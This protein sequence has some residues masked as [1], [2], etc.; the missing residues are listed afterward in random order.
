MPWEPPVVE[1]KLHWHF[2]NATDL[3]IEVAR[4]AYTIETRWWIPDWDQ[5]H[6][7]RDPAKMLESGATGVWEERPGN[8][9]LFYF[10]DGVRIPPGETIPVEVPINIGHLMPDGAH[11][12]SIAR[13]VDARIQW[14]LFLDNA[15]RRWETRPG[16]SGRARRIRAMSRRRSGYPLGWQHPVPIKLR[17][18]R[19]SAD[20]RVQRWWP[21]SLSD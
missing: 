10:V 14:V 18:V 13:G 17:A 3:P 15:G 19:A 12:L 11:Q 5:W 9:S 7:E 8:P 2:R 4:V 16:S 6:G 1:G 21:W 20:S